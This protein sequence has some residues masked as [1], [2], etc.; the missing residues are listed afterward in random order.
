MTVLLLLLGVWILLAAFLAAFVGKCMAVGLG[1]GDRP[2]GLSRRDWARIT[3]RHVP[4]G[5]PFPR[6]T[7]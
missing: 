1:T 4:H 5:M 7:R 3:E 6:R 2:D